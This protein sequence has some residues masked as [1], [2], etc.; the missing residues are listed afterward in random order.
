MPRT[1]RDV[2]PGLAMCARL[3][4]SRR[5]IATAGAIAACGVFASSPAAALPP[6]CSQSGDTATCTYTSGSNPFSVPAGVSSLHVV[7]V[8]GRGG[9]GAGGP[10]DSL[11]IGAKGGLGAVVS[12]DIPVQPGATLYAAVGGNGTVNGAAGANGGGSGGSLDLDEFVV[13]SGG[14]GGGGS[15]L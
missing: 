12:G 5:T 7:A 4:L 3:K 15:D 1:A 10:S 9:S 11:T 13:D 14:G 6:G 8:G 2:L